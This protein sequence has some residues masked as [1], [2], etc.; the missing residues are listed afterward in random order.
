VLDLL[1]STETNGRKKER[2][3]YTHTKKRYLKNIQKQFPPCSTSFAVPW[4]LS[5]PG[6]K[7]DRSEEP[8][9]PPTAKQIAPQQEQE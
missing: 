8:I 3:K 1:A 9:L 6:G 4:P 2:E 5:P 7:I